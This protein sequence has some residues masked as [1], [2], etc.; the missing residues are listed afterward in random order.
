M[1]VEMVENGDGSFFCIFAKK[2]TVP[3]FLLFKTEAYSVDGFDVIDTVRGFEFF[4]DIADVLF[5]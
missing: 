4:T 3:I 5:E 2:R 1:K